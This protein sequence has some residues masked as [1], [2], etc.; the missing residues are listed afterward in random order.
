MAMRDS[1]AIYRCHLF[2]YGGP[3]TEGVESYWSRG[4][5]PVDETVVDSGTWVELFVSIMETDHKLDENSRIRFDIL[6]EDFLLTGGTD[7]LIASIRGTGATAG[8]D[9]FPHMIE[10]TTKLIMAEGAQTA[11]DA[12][13]AFMCEKPDGY[14][15]HVLVVEMLSSPKVWHVVTWWKAEYDSDFGASDFYFII[16]VDDAFEDQTNDVLN[17]S[18]TSVASSAFSLALPAACGGSHTT[19][20]AVDDAV[21]VTVATMTLDEVP[22]TGSLKRW[23]AGN[24]TQ[25]VV[26]APRDPLDLPPDTASPFAGDADKVIADTGEDRVTRICNAA[27]WPHIFLPHPEAPVGLDQVI[28]GPS[29]LDKRLVAVLPGQR[30]L[31]TKSHRYAKSYSIVRALQWGWILFGTRAFVIIEGPLMTNPETDKRDSAYYTIPLDQPVELRTTKEQTGQERARAGGRNLFGV[32]VKFWLMEHQAPDGRPCIVRLIGCANQFDMLIPFFSW[33]FYCELEREI[34]GL[35]AVG[36]PDLIEIPHDRARKEAFSRVEKARAA[37]KEQ[38]AADELSYL[39]RAA[40]VLLEPAER[41]TYIILLLDAYT[42]EAQERAI[43]EIV[44]SVKDYDEF[45]ALLATIRQKEKFQKLLDDLDYKLWDLLQTIGTRFGDKVTWQMDRDFLE[46]MLREAAG[47]SGTG[48]MTLLDQIEIKRDGDSIMVKFN[49]KI[50]ADLQEAGM[51]LLRFL[52]S[53]VEGVWMMLSHPDKLVEGIWQLI[54][55]AV[56]FKLAGAPYFYPPAQHFVDKLIKGIGQQIAATYRGSLLLDAGEEIRRRVKWMILVEIASLLIGVGE[57]RAALEAASSALRIGDRVAGLARL[58]RAVSSVGEIESV[59]AKMERLAVLMANEGRV[60]SHT[61]EGIRLMSALPTEDLTL[62]ERA[63]SK[64]KLDD[65]PNATKLAAASPEVA[66]AL[67][68]VEP[69]LK[70]LQKIEGK[71]IC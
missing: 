5:V 51:A 63:L 44:R 1:G 41:A 25:A 31:M 11:Q 24:H 27:P 18:E 66:A 32:Q 45:T 30:Y 6:E 15:D 10:K 20:T 52:V 46:G 42:Y 8:K 28:N 49:A 54:K 2:S 35:Q 38:E 43:V 59:T 70:I 56:M 37:G 3:Q 14:R 58:A 16:N 50:L 61:E 33:D 62:L 39:G 4:L 67:E 12:V 53:T 71:M 64:A 47:A 65:V 34:L 26:P 13:L 19:P 29:F 60:I 23:L 55:M 40:F 17:V 22:T 68:R 36:D 48:F 69:K 57:I 9:E 21:P 7:D